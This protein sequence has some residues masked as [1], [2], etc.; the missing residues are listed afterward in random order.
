MTINEVRA[1]IEGIEYGF[2]DGKPNAK[3]WAAIKG[4]L[5]RLAEVKP[6]EPDNSEFTPVWTGPVTASMLE[7]GS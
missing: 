5:N 1:F 2:V 4:K 6:A 7:G 3:Q